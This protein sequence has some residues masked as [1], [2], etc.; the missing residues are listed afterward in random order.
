MCS[1]IQMHYAQISE[2][3]GGLEPR[4]TNRKRVISPLNRLGSMNC[5]I[6]NSF[7]TYFSSA[8]CTHPMNGLFYPQ[9]SIG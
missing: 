9:P 2:C 6:W 8:Y 1:V 4:A 7:N 3:V 5:G